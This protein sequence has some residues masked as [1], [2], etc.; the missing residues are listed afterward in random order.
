MEK[1]H[2]YRHAT[3]PLPQARYDLL[4][5]VYGFTYNPHQLILNERLRLDA[6][7]I[8]MFD[9]AHCLVVDGIADVEMGICMKTLH[10]TSTNYVERGLCVGQWV[11]P[12]HACNVSELFA[13]Q[14]IRA[15]IISLALLVNFSPSHLCSHVTSSTLDCIVASSCHA[16]NRCW[17]RC[18]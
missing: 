3:L 12:R 7:S 6:V 14:T 1:L 17:P 13:T 9:W 16:S 8:V 11:W 4:E 2:S 10:R 18:G 15:K 5:S